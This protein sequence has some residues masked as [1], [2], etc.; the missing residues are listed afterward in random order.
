MR[1]EHDALLRDERT[2]KLLSIFAEVMTGPVLPMPPECA[3]TGERRKAYAA[4]CARRPSSTTHQT[5]AEARAR[6][7][8]PSRSSSSQRARRCPVAALSFYQLRLC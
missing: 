5:F 6:P 2:A 7:P 1:L 4:Q 3:G 8:T